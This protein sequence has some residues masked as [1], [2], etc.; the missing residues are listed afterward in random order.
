MKALSNTELASFCSQFALILGSGISSF[1]GLSIMLED[2]PKGDARLLLEMLLHDVET[3]ESLFDALTRSEC[4]P[5]YMCSMVQIG[6]QSGRLD[7]VMNSLSA[8]YRREELLSRNMKS[9]VTYPF[10]MLGMMIAIMIVLAVKVLPVFHQ[11]FEQLG[12]SLGGLAGTV[13]AVGNAL[14]NYSTVCIVL[15]SLFAVLFF[16]FSG[17]QKGRNFMR[18]F[19]A[20][21]FMT[22][23]LSEKIACSRFADGMYLALCS[24]LDLDESLEMVSVL[25]EHPVVSGKIQNI[26]KLIQEG[27][28]FSEAVTKTALFSGVCS[29]MISVGVKTGTMDQVMRQIAD[30]YEEEIEEQMDSMVSKIEP[31]LVAVLSV[32]VGMI[33]LSVMLPLMGIMSHMG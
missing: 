33:L 10:I 2:T 29:R 25:V 27:N 6:E 18:K 32:A 22:R 17:T 15:L 5:V 23:H 11:V 21:F 9:A 12:A 24:G 28:S 20:D 14:R 19:F 7:D 8:H 1:E 30:R 13:L 31:A 26:R 3:G 4:F 16:Y